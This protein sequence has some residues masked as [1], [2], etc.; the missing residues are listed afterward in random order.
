[1]LEIKNLNNRKYILL[2][3]PIIL[4]AS[5][6]PLK[7]YEKSVE[8][9][10][11]DE[12]LLIIPNLI[13]N[14]SI[15]GN[16]IF[17]SGSNHTIINLKKIKNN[18]SKSKIITDFYGNT[19]KVS[20]LKKNSIRI[21]NFNLVNLKL[22][23]YDLSILSKKYNI[24]GILGT[25]I[26]SKFS[27]KFDYNNKKLLI[28][29]KPFKNDTL[30]FINVDFNNKSL[31]KDKI[32]INGIYKND[33]I[34]DSGS[35]SEINTNDSLLAL[36]D[37][38]NFIEQNLIR[39]LASKNYKN[40]KIY[41]SYNSKIDIG[42][43]KFND[44]KLQ[45]ESNS[46]NLIGLDFFSRTI[47]VFDGKA[48]KFYFHSQAKIDKLIKNRRG[49][50]FGLD[51]NDNIFVEAITEKGE[52]YLKGIKIGDIIVGID[53]LN[54]FT[55]KKRIEELNQ[56]RNSINELSIERNNTILHFKFDDP[57][58]SKIKE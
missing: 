41:L 13:V 8:Y 18:V 1:V 49:L 2:M 53:K 34:L 5:C 26:I 21:A 29:N 15:K 4:L 7:D 33:F 6:H 47:F 17:D 52:S 58:F 40:Y 12:G 16:F 14:D 11:I 30:S 56:L 43:H 44:C 3:L 32:K 46:R 19:D 38:T 50:R 54:I 25:D 57:N 27:W 10:F 39:S 45:A 28:S 9:N 24:I 37:P 35:L 55:Y 48:S 42:I 51:E 36:K 23:A 20:I 22:R 31:I